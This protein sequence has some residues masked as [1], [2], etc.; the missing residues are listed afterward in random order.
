MIKIDRN[1]SKDTGI[2][3]ALALA[4]YSLYTA[5]FIYLKI[6]IPILAIAL[7]CPIVLYPVAWL[8]FGFSMILGAITSRIILSLVYFILIFPL[9]LLFRLFGKDDLMLRKFKKGKESVFIDRQHKF[10]ASDLE[11]PF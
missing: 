2:V 5:D 6:G 11:K 1:K 7:I 4:I 8:W 9:S 3:L 10:V